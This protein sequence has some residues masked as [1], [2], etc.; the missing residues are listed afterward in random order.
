MLIGRGPSRSLVR[1]KRRKLIIERHRLSLRAAVLRILPDED[2][3]GVFE[4]LEFDKGEE[5]LR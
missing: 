3:P 1:N 4:D 5:G 2:V